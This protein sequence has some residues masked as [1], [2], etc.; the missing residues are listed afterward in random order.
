MSKPWVV[1]TEDDPHSSEGLIIRYF[2]HIARNDR[3]SAER[4]VG[5][6]FM[7]TTEEGDVIALRA[8]SRLLGSDPDGVREVLSLPELADGITDELA[9]AVPLFYLELRIP[10]AAAAIKALPWFQDKLGPATI[11]DDDRGADGIGKLQYLAVE[12]PQVFWAVMG[13][14]WIQATQ[15]GFTRDRVIAILFI[16]QIAEVDVAS[17]MQILALPFLESIEPDDER[18]L[19]TL[20]D[21]FREDPDG[22]RQL[23]SDPALLDGTRASTAADVALLYL[24]AQGPEV[25]A[26]IEALPWVQDGIE[27]LRDSN[28][29]SFYPSK[30]SL[31]SWVVFD[32]TH[33]YFNSRGTF[34]S[35]VQSPWV[36]DGLNNWEYTALT[37]LLTV[38][39]RDPTA[40]SRIMEMPFLKT[41]E[42]HDLIALSTMETLARSGSDSLQQLLS[43]PA[44]HG[45]VTDDHMATVALLYLKLLDPDAAAAIG[46][47]P[48]VQDGIAALEQRPVRAL[49][50]L[51]LE[52]PKVFWALT[53]RSWTQDGL[54]ADEMTVVRQLTSMSGKSYGRSAE[55]A[56]LGIID[57]PFLETIDGLD[58]AAMR[59]LTALALGWDQGRLQQVLSHPTLSNG[60]T[61]IRR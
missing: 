16:T 51:A 41:F 23:L 22:A 11:D 17:A 48:W 24:K 53:H 1:E 44:L 46:S 61:M 21:L 43:D 5:M 4:L 26:A 2:V 14:P 35:L 34:L 54:S 59:S 18:K 13:R 33:I 55:A 39:H 27:P 50:G 20:R 36:Y 60:I 31:E 57:M 40:A 12:S 30:A 28:V 6:P 45:G 47:L 10:E 7:Q 58:A 56:A 8:L 32:L 15:E 37:R 9:A 29:G 19:V 25:S 38:A 49:Q 3:E 52:S 42:R